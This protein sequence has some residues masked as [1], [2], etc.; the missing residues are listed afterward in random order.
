MRLDPPRVFE[1]TI[2]DSVWQHVFVDSEIASLSQCISGP[3]QGFTG[4]KRSLSQMLTNFGWRELPAP[5][6]AK[7]FDPATLDWEGVGHVAPPKP[8]P[9][10]Q[11]WRF[12]YDK[13]APH[14]LHAYG[15]KSGKPQWDVV[16]FERPDKMQAELTLL[17]QSL[18][19][20]HEREKQ[21]RALRAAAERQRDDAI[22]KAD[23]EYQ[24]RC[25]A[26]SK[27]IEHYDDCLCELRRQSQAAWMRGDYVTADRIAELIG[28]PKP[29]DHE[30]AE[31]RG[32]VRS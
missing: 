28:D 12:F 32:E 29:S 1:C 17:R 16:E 11:L 31:L 18:A 9:D 10:D 21:E 23:F 13:G 26:A 3:C 6:E 4:D 30:A 5:P 27:K 24:C 14:C 2:M 8:I 15:H 19:E 25:E 20:A 22:A 7:A